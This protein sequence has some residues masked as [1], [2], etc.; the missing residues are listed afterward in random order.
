M[1][2]DELAEELRTMRETARPGPPQ[3]GRQQNSKKGKEMPGSYGSW[4]EV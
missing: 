3:P 1:S 4:E 2:I